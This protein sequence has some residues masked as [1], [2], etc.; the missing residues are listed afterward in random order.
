MVP[1]RCSYAEMY[2]PEF[3]YPSKWTQNFAMFETHREELVAFI[4]ERLDN[5]E[6][7]Q[8]AMN[9]Q[10]EVLKR[11]YLNAKIMIDNLTSMTPRE[12][13]NG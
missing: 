7:F 2:L 5:P 12:G 6:R 13:A 9:R 10:R 8:E 1:D 11:D 4:R 3:R